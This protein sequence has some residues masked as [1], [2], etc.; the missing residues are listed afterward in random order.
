MCCLFI[1]KGRVIFNSLQVYKNIFICINNVVD[2]LFRYYAYSRILC[3]GC[4]VQR[5][6]FCVGVKFII[7]GDYIDALFRFY[8]LCLA[9]LG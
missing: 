1:G 6:I 5:L 8:S 4:I 3:D 7:V 9:K 2:Y